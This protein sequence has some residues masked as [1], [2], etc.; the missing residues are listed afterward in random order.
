VLC[1]HCGNCV[2][3]PYQAIVLDRNGV[4]TFDPGCCVG[5]SLCA[6]KCFSGAIS[7]RDRTPPELA[8]LQEH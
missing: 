3:C 8:A 4:P 6:Q 7:M 2:R 1:H 5:C